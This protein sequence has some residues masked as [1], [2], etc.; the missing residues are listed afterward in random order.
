MNSDDKE[1]RKNLFIKNF[2]KLEIYAKKKNVNIYLE[3]NCLTKKNIKFMNGNNLML[4]NLDDYS[5]LKKKINFK[6][7]L[8][9]GHL[10][11]SSKSNK[12]DFFKEADVLLSKA[13]YI[14]I[15]DNN[16]KEDLN[17]GITKN[18][19]VYK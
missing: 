5:E 3:N 11:V 2:K 1:L 8:D 15:S 18:S 19:D 12:L 17:L 4:T 6:F 13:N 16:S 9:I 7:L 14:H 10:K